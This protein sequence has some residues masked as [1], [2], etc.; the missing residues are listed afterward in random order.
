M[1]RCSAGFHP[2][3]ARRPLREEWQYLAPRL[4]T[5]NDNRARR[6][7][8]VNLKDRFGEVDADRADLLLE[9]GSR[10]RRRCV[11]GDRQRRVALGPR[12]GARVVLPPLRG[13]RSAFI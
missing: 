1:M 12:C 3:Q 2:D 11:A 6:I 13:R 10:W 8:T 4:L 7:D 9:K 5:A